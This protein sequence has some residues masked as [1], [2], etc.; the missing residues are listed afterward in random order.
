MSFVHFVRAAV[1][2]GSI[3]LAP[4]AS[5]ESSRASSPGPPAGRRPNLL[6]SVIVALD[7]VMIIG[8]M[9]GAFGLG[10]VL[11]EAH[12]LAEPGNH[13]LLGG[14]SLPLW[15]AIFFHYRLYSANHVASRRDEL[16]RLLHAIGAAVVGMATLGFMARIDV[17][18]G[19]L[20]LVFGLASI[21]LMTEREVVRRC[22]RRRRR[23]GRLV[24]RVVIVGGNSDGLALCANLL[25]D[26]SLGYEVAGFVDDDLDCDHMLVGR[27]V[28]GRICDARGAVEAVGAQGVIMVASA[29][30]TKVSNRLA[31]ELAEHGI[32]IELLP[33]LVGV[34]G[35]RLNIRSVGRF[36]IVDLGPL[37]HKGW[38][39]VAKRIFDLGI[40]GTALVLTSPL[41]VVI[42]VAIWLD[43]AG[44]VLFRQERVGVGGRTFKI[45][46]FRSMVVDAEARLR[47][48]ADRNEASGPLFKVRRDPRVTRVGRFLRRFSLDE[49]PQFWNVVRGEMSIVGPRPALPNELTGWSPDL[50]QRLNVRPGITGL[51]QVGARS[52]ASF[53]EYVHLDLYYVDNWSLMTDLSIMA[54]TIPAVLSRRGAY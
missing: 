43:S 27:P 11:K 30:D 45:L 24:R 13:V 51:W 9:V 14:L 16:G 42:S 54:Q 15:V 33:S 19:W 18:R 23:D 44:P 34:A 39:W 22:L 26:R 40:A 1:A 53:D 6:K 3:G 46:K 12:V 35:G 41:L 31:R 21:L 28:L 2:T 32:R 29:M 17:A 52:D 4:N 7:L 8:A 38:R 37:C 48:L 25:V 20:G 49:L 10:L 36:P 50:H 5:V 47:Q